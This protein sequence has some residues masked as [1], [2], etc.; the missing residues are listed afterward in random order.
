MRAENILAID[1]GSQS[2]RALVVDPRGNLLAKSR[3]PIPIHQSPASG[4]M[5]QDP[6]VFWNALCLACQRLW[7]MPEVDKNSIAAVALTTQRSTVINVDQ[8]GTDR[9]S[10]V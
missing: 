5:E 10:V 4:F 2:V 6:Q 7:Q 1:N 3:I 9:K 8:E